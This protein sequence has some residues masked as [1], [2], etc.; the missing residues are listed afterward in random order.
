MRQRGRDGEG[1][2]E[3]AYWASAVIRPLG[4]TGSCC[5]WANAPL[6]ASG[7]A[8]AVTGPQCLLK[9]SDVGSISTRMLTVKSSDFRGPIGNGTGWFIFQALIVNSPQI[10]SRHKPEALHTHCFSD[11]TL[12]SDCQYTT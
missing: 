10:A 8:N 5:C 9:A 4:E 11:W 6:A 3:Q 2:S 7:P 1:G 12:P